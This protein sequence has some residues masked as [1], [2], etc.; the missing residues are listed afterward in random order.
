MDGHHGRVEGDDRVGDGDGAGFARFQVKVVVAEASRLM[1]HG[2]GDKISV[3]RCPERNLDLVAVHRRD[4]NFGRLWLALEVF[5]H[6]EKMAVAQAGT[7][8]CAH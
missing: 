2:D 8:A 7:S 1:G 6:G 4:D 5:H 3:D